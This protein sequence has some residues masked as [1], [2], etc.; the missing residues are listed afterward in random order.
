MLGFPFHFGVVLGFLN[1]K[2]FETLNLKAV[3]HGK[4]EKIDPSIIRRTLI[5]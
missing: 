4:A 1:L 2:W 5:L 3:M